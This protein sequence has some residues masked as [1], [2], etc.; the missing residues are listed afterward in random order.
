MSSSRATSARPSDP[1][2]TE[3]AP[4]AADVTTA[5]AATAGAPAADAESEAT[6]TVVWK[7]GTDNHAKIV[8]PEWHETKGTYR[9]DRDNGHTIEMPAS[10]AD[11][12]MASADKAEFRVKK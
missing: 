4:A 11:A 6:K 7:N 12:I 5:G 3:N 9:F 1:T 2:V 10:D 8:D